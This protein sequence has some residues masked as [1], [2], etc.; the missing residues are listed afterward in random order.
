MAEFGHFAQAALHQLFFSG[1]VWDGDL[2][3]KSGR[4]EL[5]R[6]QMASRK[7]GWNFITGDGITF[8]IDIGWA[9]VKSAG[10]KCEP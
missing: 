7:E 5:V 3:D 1:P 4:D 8:A 9:A 2:V 6:Y 10:R